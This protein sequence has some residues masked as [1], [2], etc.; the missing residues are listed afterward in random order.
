[1]QNNYFNNKTL[2]KNTISHKKPKTIEKESSNLRFYFCIVVVGAVLYLKAIRFDFVG[3]DDKGTLVDNQKYFSDIY[4][5]FRGF[6][7][8]YWSSFY[9][10]ILF[11]SIILDFQYMGINPHLY[12][13]TNIIYHIIC[14]CL[15]FRL[16]LFL[17]KE[18][19][20]AFI[21]TLLFTVHPLFTQA[22]GW[23]YGRN[24]TLLGIFTILSF[25]YFGSFLKINQQKYFWIHCI[26]YAISLFVKETALVI[27]LICTVYYFLFIHFQNKNTD[28]TLLFF[29]ILWVLISILWAVIRYTALEFRSADEIARGLI[30]QEEI[31]GV[32]AFLKNVP[33]L[34]EALGKFLFP[35]NLSVYPSFHTF[36]TFLGVALYIVIIFLLFISKKRNYTTSLF[37]FV[38]WFVFLIPPIFIYYTDGRYDYLEHRIY[39]PAIGMVFLLGE[40]SAMIPPQKVKIFGGIIISIFFILTWIHLDNFK[41]IETFWTSAAKTSPKKI[42]PNKWS[43]MYYDQM[44]NT[45]KST[46]YLHKILQID[47]HNLYALDLLSLFYFKKKEYQKAKLLLKRSVNINNR[48]I[49]LIS[50]YGY[51]LEKENKWDS[52]EI[53]FRKAAALD[54][55]KTYF[56]IYKKIGDYALRKGQTDSAKKYY[57]TSLAIDAHQVSVLLALGDIVLA[58]KNIPL[59]EKCWLKALSLQPQN[60][61]LYERLIQIYI[62][63]K[64]TE[65]AK[66][67]WDKAQKKGIKVMSYKL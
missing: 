26:F 2:K 21:L 15:L 32:D 27:P 31:V 39:V 53:Y 17:K 38:W 9:R 51:I 14:C 45:T 16:L 64:E 49:N 41:G 57:K 24:D 6:Y 10:P 8:S 3:L 56:K 63:Q 59:A 48:D 20:I 65:K 25:F 35:Y 29:P 44:G 66:Q 52:A 47:S 5:L 23:V 33:F 46:E 55:S 36:T 1:M 19:S 18:K 67:I 4:N 62:A 22:V 60:K 40:V 7:E 54:T 37:A 42:S 43:A 11:G 50:N 61:I 28:K 12:H 13:L 34:F 30:K 58:E